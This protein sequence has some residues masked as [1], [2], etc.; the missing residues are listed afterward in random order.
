MTGKVSLTFMDQSGEFSRVEY[1]VPDTDGA[2]LVNAIDD[3][4]P[5]TAGSTAALIAALSLCTPVGTQYT[6][7]KSALPPTPPGSMYAQRE[8]GLM[9]EYAD[10]VTAKK[11][12]I[13]VPGPQW[14]NIGLTG[15]DVVDPADPSWVAFK[16]KFE[17]EAVSP[18]GN[19]ITVMGAH[20]V[21]RNR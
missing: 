15:Q 18:D 17:A 9:V 4:K 14:D 10:N 13:T 1:Y 21:G 20:L 2:G 3:S 6:I 16:A 5:T 11:Y 7:Y 8:L 12:R 19:A